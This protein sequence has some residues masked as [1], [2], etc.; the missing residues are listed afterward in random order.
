[1]KGLFCGLLL[2][3]CSTAVFA[4]R[5]VWQQIRQP[6]Q[7][8]QPTVGS[9]AIGSY[10]N[11]CLAGG[12]A[13]PLQNAN[14]Q[15]LRP[16][17]HRFYGHPQLINFIEQLANQTQQQHLGL[18]LVGDMGLPAGGRFQRGHASH[19]L[20]LDVDIWLQLPQQRWSA[21]Q[22]LYPQAIDLVSA[23]G[24][25]VNQ[26]WQPDIGQL[27]RLAA[28]Q[29]QVTRIFVHPAIK[30][31]LCLANARDDR[32][33]LHKVRPWF[34]HRAHMHIRLA[35]P[36]NNPDCQPQVEPPAGDGCGSEL[37]SW[38]LPAKPQPPQSKPLPPPM[39]LRCQ[40]LLNDNSLAISG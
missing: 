10:A 2:V 7:F 6:L 40:Q 21:Q 29:P 12:Q 9:D 31:A 32:Q 37:A 27:I 24:K 28:E 22:L 34:G 36:S 4:Q 17:Q 14:Y 13:L 8:N 39:P 18:L 3:I 5:T 1:M 19:Q 11:G 38:F 30:Q 25:Q 20:G 15:V 35:C 23:S 26:H 33:W 16:D